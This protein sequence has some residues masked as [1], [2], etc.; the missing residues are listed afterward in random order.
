MTENTTAETAVITEAPSKQRSVGQKKGTVIDIKSLMEAGAHFGHQR[1]KWNPKM[2]Q[3]IFGEKNGVHILD[4]DQTVS[5]WEIARKF[6]AD[7]AS[8][9]ASI[10]FVGTKAQIRDVVRQE[11][12][13]CGA[14]YVNTRWLGGTLTN[15]GTIKKSIE[16]MKKIEDLLERSLIPDSKVRIAKKE[17]VAMQ[18]QLDTLLANLGGIRDMRKQ[19]DVAIIFDTVKE[20]LAVAES[21]TLKIPVVA[22]CDSNCDPTEIDLPIPAN[23]DA[24]KS[25]TLFAS[26]LADAVIEGFEIFKIN[27]PAMAAAMLDGSA[28]ME[29]PAPRTERKRPGGNRDRNDRGG[30]RGGQRR[31][32]DR[33]SSGGDRSSTEK[34]AE[35]KPAEANSTEGVTAA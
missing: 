29:E 3:Y 1:E 2:M 10:L 19:P 35:A 23:D 6:V 26:A 30:D 5:K 31:G 11:A 32:S 16:R 22:L 13:R 14:F 9:G 27:A 24:T 25:V 17:R 21:R 33:N 15:F 18:K 8:L 7:R 28:A 34:P 20:D 4:L 12:E